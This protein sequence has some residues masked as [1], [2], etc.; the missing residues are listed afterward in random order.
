M[1]KDTLLFINGVWREGKGGISEDVL[2]P[3]NGQVLGTV[4]HAGPSDL[5]DALAS[6]QAGFQIW[7]KTPGTERAAILHKT[8]A[9]I[10]ERSDEI[11]AIMTLE[12]GKPLAE[13]K[14]EMER[15][16]ET[17]SYNAAAIAQIS[18][19][20]YDPPGG[21]FRQ[22]VR[23]EPLGVT[24]GLTAWNFPAILPARKLGPALAAGCSMILKASEETPRT[25][26]ELVKAL[27]DAGLPAGVVNLVFGVPSDVSST[28]LAADPVRKVSFTGSVP[29]GKLLAGLAAPG[30]KRLTLELGGHAPA[31]VCEDADINAATAA[32]TGFKFRNAGQVCIA[33]SR[34][35]VHERHYDTFVDAFVAAA[36][37]Q[38]IGDGMD[39]ATTFGPM[40]NER[41]VEVMEQLTEDA[42]A[43]GAA[44]LTGGKRHGN[45]GY[46]WEP[47]V[48][49]DVPDDARVMTEEPF[50]PIAPIARFSNLEDVIPKANGLPFGLAA[51]AFAGSS[52]TVSYLADQLEAGGVAINAVT[53]MRADTPFGGMK[54]SGIGYEGGMEAI[55]SYMH[56]KLVS[57]GL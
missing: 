38:T 47:T 21:A 14:G 1:Y 17:F 15:V 54:D 23:P 56:K 50:G 22:A 9:L 25:A 16:V 33:P 32:L 57:T 4:A 13:A 52:E 30:L 48:L 36:T 51:Y 35:Y 41:R 2:N 44:V 49:T 31:I 43:K 27:H 46:F 5:A 28:L 45:Q 40:A 55:E 39:P 11:A 37:D 19:Q 20:N 24:V 26:A 3:A 10:A 34:F 29:V 12:Q 42:R 18:E 8:A 6:A 7:R 53:P